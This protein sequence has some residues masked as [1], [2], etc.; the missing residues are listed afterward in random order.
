MTP[1]SRNIRD[2]RR[3]ANMTQKA[4][5]AQADVSAAYVTQIE[6]GTRTPS[7]PT[8]GRFAEV[9]DTTP[10]RLLR[11][12]AEDVSL[13]ELKHRLLDSLRIVDDLEKREHWRSTAP[14][15]GR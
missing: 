2:L 3:L 10:E 8:L 14:G 7:M 6:C 5:A 4:L 13:S 1:L 9:L 15:S 11:A 12:P